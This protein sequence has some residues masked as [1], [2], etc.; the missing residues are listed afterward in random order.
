VVLGR[1]DEA[2]AAAEYLQTE[3]FAVRAIR[4]PTVNSGRARLRLSITSAIGAEELNRLEYCLA[5]WRSQ[6]LALAAG[7]S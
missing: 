3:G 1:N 4:P 6:R 7:C 2:M 5:S